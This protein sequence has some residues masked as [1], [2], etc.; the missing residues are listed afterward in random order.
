VAGILGDDFGLY[1]VR[2]RLS[3]RSE[4]RPVTTSP[5]DHRE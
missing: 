3:V 2:E 5:G 1:D 4:E